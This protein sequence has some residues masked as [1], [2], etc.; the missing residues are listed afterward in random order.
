[1]MK[2]FFFPHWILVAG[3]GTILVG[4]HYAN[5]LP[6]RHNPNGIT[7]ICVALDGDTL[8][9]G[10]QPI[11]LLG[12]DAAELPGHC[13]PGRDCAPGDPFAQKAELARISRSGPL[14]IYPVKTDNWGRTVATVV[15][16]QGSNVS[17]TLV[18]AGVRYV[19]KWDDGF[20]TLRA[21]PQVIARGE[22]GTIR[23]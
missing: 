5:T 12:I 21:C 3:V 14:T 8:K 18:A 7:S 23:E 15:D 10:R 22:Q 19:S 9:C 20:G 2:R 17:C 6:S 13:R 1:M 4:Q 16:G 11:R